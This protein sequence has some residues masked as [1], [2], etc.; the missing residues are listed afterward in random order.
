MVRR[1]ASPLL[2][3]RL[4]NNIR[5]MSSWQSLHPPRE[6]RIAPGYH[7][8]CD[9]H[10]SPCTHRSSHAGEQHTHVCRVLSPTT[11]PPHTHSL[12]PSPPRARWAVCIRSLLPP[13]LHVPARTPAGPP[14]SLQ[15]MPGCCGHPA[16]SGQGW[17]RAAPSREARTALQGSYFL[18]W[19]PTPEALCP[20]PTALPGA[21]HRMWVRDVSQGQPLAQSSHHLNSALPA[22]LPPQVLS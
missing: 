9:A 2:W 4:A 8:G 6:Q 13:L 3:H 11:P 14:L 17:R 16:G 18:Q 7:T 1:T 5:L 15:L 22:F 21:V 20:L 12:A 19:V 10:P